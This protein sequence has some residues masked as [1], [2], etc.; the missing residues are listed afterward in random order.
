MIQGICV[1]K[2]KPLNFKFERSCGTILAIALRFRWTRSQ[3]KRISSRV[4]ANCSKLKSN[5]SSLQFVVFLE[6]I[7][8]AHALGL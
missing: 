6:F 4:V 5:Q 7:H 8:R 2:F 3:F 1:W